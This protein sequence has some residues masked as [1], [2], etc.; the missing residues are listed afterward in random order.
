ML[1][2]RSKQIMLPIAALLFIT[3]SAF[4]QPPGMQEQA[5]GREGTRGSR[6]A[7]YKGMIPGLSEEQQEQIKTLRT[8]H[9]KAVQPLRNQLGEKKARLRTLTTADKV[10]MTEVNKVIDEI[11]MLQTKMMK[12]KVQHQQSIRGLLTDEQRVFFDSHQPGHDGPRHEGMQQRKEM[13]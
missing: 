10:N 7:E 4:A 3:G 6:M 8:E 5:A 2:P 1:K 11:G 9:M 13:R 12:L